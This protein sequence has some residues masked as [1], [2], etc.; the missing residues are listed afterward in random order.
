MRILGT[1]TIMCEMSRLLIYGDSSRIRTIILSNKA[2]KRVTSF[3]RYFPPVAIPRKKDIQLKMNGVFVLD[4]SDVCKDHNKT[5]RHILNGWASIGATLLQICMMD[6]RKVDGSN[7]CAVSS[8]TCAVLLFP[9]V[10]FD[11]L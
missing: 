3:E 2:K 8:L 1:S 5:S 10:H 6:P 9:C 4:S 7:R 11:S